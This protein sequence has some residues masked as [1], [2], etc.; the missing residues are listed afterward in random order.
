MRIRP[1]RA[2]ALHGAVECLH[3]RRRCRGVINRRLVRFGDEATSGGE[4]Q[5]MF[6]WCR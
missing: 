6:I 1:R 5:T 2:Q 3:W 4:L